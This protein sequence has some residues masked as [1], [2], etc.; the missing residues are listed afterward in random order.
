M[1][2]VIK[3][4]FRDKITKELYKVD[5]VVEFTEERAK[6]LLADNRGLVEEAKEAK[7]E[8]VSDE[9]KK[10]AKKRTTKKSK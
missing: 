3:K 8:E 10:V 9:P 5:D 1:R 6:E 2:L 7:E 4:V